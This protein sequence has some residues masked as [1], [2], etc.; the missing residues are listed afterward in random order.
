MKV[1]ELQELNSE[2]LTQKLQDFKRKLLHDNP[3]RLYGI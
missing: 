2:E 1:A 3:R